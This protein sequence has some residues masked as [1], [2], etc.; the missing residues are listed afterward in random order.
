MNQTEERIA[1]TV[2]ILLTTENGLLEM[3]GN[4]GCSTQQLQSGQLTPS[5]IA[6]LERALKLPESFFAF[7]DS[8]TEAELRLLRNLQLAGPEQIRLRGAPPVA[9]LSQALETA[10]R[11]GSSDAQEQ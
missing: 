11:A 1:F 3:S 9:F 5:Q 2:Q 10:D 4:L 8:K 6:G 7:G